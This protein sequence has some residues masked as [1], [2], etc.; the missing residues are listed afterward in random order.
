[1]S[2]TKHDFFSF[3]HHFIRLFMKKSW[4]RKRVEKRFQ[5]SNKICNYFTLTEI[6][7]EILYTVLINLNQNLIMRKKSWYKLELL[8]IY[9]N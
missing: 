3:S 1:M 2:Q 8:N 9:Q 4:K 7:T 6:E 5:Q